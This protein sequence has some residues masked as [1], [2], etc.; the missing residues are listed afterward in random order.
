MSLQLLA[1]VHGYVQR[2]ALSSFADK[3]S[4]ALDSHYPLPWSR[5][6]APF[7]GGK[8]LLDAL[9]SAQR[10]QISLT[11]HRLDHLSVLAERAA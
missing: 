2:I 6:D 7:A 3:S 11:P 9:L 5:L 8:S 4:A 10:Q 1:V